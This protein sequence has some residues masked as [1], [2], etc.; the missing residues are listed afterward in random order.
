MKVGVL[1]P[2]TSQLVEKMAALF[3]EGVDLIGPQADD[4][5]YWNNCRLRLDGWE[6]L[7][8]KVTIIEEPYDRLDFHGYDLLIESVETFQYSKNWRSHCL[9]LECPVMLKVC[10]TDNPQNLLPRNYLK[11]MKDFPVLLEMPTHAP[12]WRAAGFQD[13][14]VASD[15]FRRCCVA[16]KMLCVRDIT[17]AYWGRSE[18]KENACQPISRLRTLHLRAN[19]RSVRHLSINEH[20]VSKSLLQIPFASM[21]WW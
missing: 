12:N 5:H 2:T 4:R 20:I 13:V 6:E 11:K 1:S 15:L 10:W 16:A 7:G 19:S 17:F 9:R 21:Y 18:S 14:N 8:L 3:P